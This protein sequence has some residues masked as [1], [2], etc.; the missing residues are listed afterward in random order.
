MPT[1]T[2]TTPTKTPPRPRPAGFSRPTIGTH[3]A[4]LIGIFNAAQQA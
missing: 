2:G 1:T 4:A 3:N